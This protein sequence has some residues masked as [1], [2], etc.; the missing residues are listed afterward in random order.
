MSTTRW[1][2]SERTS[3]LLPAS[4][5]SSS[6]TKPSTTNE[7]SAVSR[8]GDGGEAAGLVLR[9]RQAEERVEGHEDDGE[10]AG[11]QVLGAG[12]VPDHDR[13]AVTA[14]LGTKAGDHGRRDVDA[15]DVEAG[16]GQ[17][18]GQAT[19]AD[20]ELEHATAARPAG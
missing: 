19:G 4:I 20:A 9:G 5:S 12:H 1:A 3:T 16:L 14:G 18:D 15:G 8:V 17:R 10:R 2:V 7:P 6:G 11:R 13:D